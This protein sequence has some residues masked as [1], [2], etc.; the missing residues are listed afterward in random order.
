MQGCDQTLIVEQVGRDL[1]E[2]LKEQSRLTGGQGIMKNTNTFVGLELFD[3]SSNELSEAL[4]EDESKD[5]SQLNSC[6][7]R[8]SNCLE[9][10]R[11][12]L[13]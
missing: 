10:S 6:L 13:F 7:S 2:I 5:L 1:G 9:W 8:F 4:S 3:H 12:D 11:F